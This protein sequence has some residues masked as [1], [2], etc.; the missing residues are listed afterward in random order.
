ME[1]IDLKELFE[2]LK[3]K[4]SLL[5][6]IATGVCLLGCIYGLILQKPMYKSYTTVI[7]G[8]NE[9]SNGTISQS[10]ITLNKNL[11]NTYAEIV[12]SKRVLN[13][14]IKELSLD[15]SYEALSGKISVSAVNNTEIIKISV[16]DE[17]AIKAKNIA[18]V[19]ADFFS[20]EV[21]KLY[22]INNVNI[23]DEATEATNPYNI[24]IIKQII[25]YLINDAR[26]VKYR[27]GEKNES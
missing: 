11:V 1:E 7:L 26:S 25:I 20:E 9:S 19:T 13:K 14:V 5:I 12:K 21:I 17:N 6:I 10:D 22:N 27:H 8:G 24:N 15:V 2:F 4:L 23:L 18:N 3:S 16:S